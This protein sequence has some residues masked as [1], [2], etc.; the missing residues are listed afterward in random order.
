V[1]SYKIDYNKFRNILTEKNRKSYHLAI[2]T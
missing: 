1:T 2:N